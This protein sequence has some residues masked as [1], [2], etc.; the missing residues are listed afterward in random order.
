MPK[1]KRAPLPPGRK[2]LVAHAFFVVVLFFGIRRAS[3]LRKHVNGY[4]YQASAFHTTRFPSKAICNETKRHYTIQTQRQPW[5]YFF[6]A[7]HLKITLM[8]ENS[9]ILEGY[10]DMEKGAYLGAIASLATAD[11]KATE[12]EL[13]YIR[14]LCM[15]ANLSPQQQEL[16]VQAAT[17]MTGDDLNRC[18]DVLKNS[19]LKYS[20]V[21]DLMAFA[22]ADSNYSESEQQSIHK[23]SEYLGLDQRQ[24]D[25][26]DQFSRQEVPTSPAE[27][28]EHSQQNFFGGGLKDKMQQAG[29]NTNGLLKS[30]LSIAAPMLIGGMLSG[31]R[32]GLGGAMGGMLGGGLGG[33][34]GGGGLS[35]IIGMLSGG[36]GMR[37]T[38]GLLGRMLGRRF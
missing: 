36:R 16:V 20:L 7:S 4:D 10:S 32:G 34:L 30:V 22:K 35:S 9:T 24:F 15:A 26:L 31:R 28:P 6:C 17:D 29:I 14:E 12:D 5:P 18:L 19:Q 25:L 1:K 3:G 8:P 23:I 27:Q 2:P 38:G 37:S 33:M 21:T 13:T 11:H